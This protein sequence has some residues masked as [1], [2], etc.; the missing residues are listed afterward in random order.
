MNSEELINQI[1]EYRL[2]RDPRIMALVNCVIE[3]PQDK[4]NLELLYRLANPQIVGRKYLSK[5]YKEPDETVDGQIRFALTEQS[6]PVGFNLDEPHCLVVGQTG[7]G[8]TTLL[9]L[10]LGQLL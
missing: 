2:D 10:I 6:L 3:N 4:E 8:K 1:F 5:P 7:C 9:L